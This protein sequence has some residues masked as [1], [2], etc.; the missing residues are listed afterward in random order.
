MT[1]PN[2]SQVIAVDGAGNQHPAASYKTFAIINDVLYEFREGDYW[3][4]QLDDML[5]VYDFISTK[6][7]VLTSRIGKGDPR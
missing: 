5:S 3:P 1:N 6:L 4:M 2:T 7:D